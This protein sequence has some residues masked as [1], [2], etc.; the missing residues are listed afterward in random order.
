MIKAT[1]KTIES[2][3]KELKREFPGMLLGTLGAISLRNLLT[4]KYIYAAR[5]VIKLAKEH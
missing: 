2:E 5:E 4:T 3:A 1:I